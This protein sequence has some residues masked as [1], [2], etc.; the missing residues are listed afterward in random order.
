M[1]RKDIKI[2]FMIRKDIKILFMIRKDI[3]FE[4]EKLIFIEN[5]D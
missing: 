4:S 5:V 3:F 1:R 2:L